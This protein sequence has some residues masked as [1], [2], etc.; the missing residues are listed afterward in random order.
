MTVQQE[1]ESAER[2]LPGEEAPDDEEDPRWQA[3]MAVG[4]FLDSE[5]QP[6]WAFI[7]YWGVYPDDDLRSA[8]A[9]ILLEHLLEKHFE[10][11]F[12]RV[13]QLVRANRVFAATFTSCWKF[14]QSES[15][16]NGARFD[17]LMR[18]ASELTG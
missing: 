3:I 4:E 5:P 2:I 6:I 16:A 11:F 8:I 17:A 12:P 7:E 14:G 10:R 1:I 15:S 13:Q 18:E 9:T